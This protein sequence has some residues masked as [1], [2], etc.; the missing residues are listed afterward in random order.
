MP[1]GADEKA[2]DILKRKAVALGGE[3][4]VEVSCGGVSLKNCPAARKCTGN[5]VRWN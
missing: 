2:I 5:A 1:H 3:A 4:V